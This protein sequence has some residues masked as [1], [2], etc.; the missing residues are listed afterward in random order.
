MQLRLR[1][2]SLLLCSQSV[3]CFLDGLQQ[4]SEQA[5]TQVR[6]G[7]ADMH[8]LLCPNLNL[9]TQASVTHLRQR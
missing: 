9:Q 4:V 5:H 6:I 1:M 8:Q 2:V 7:T 3:G